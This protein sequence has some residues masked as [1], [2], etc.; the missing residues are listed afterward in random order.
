MSI[1]DKFSKTYSDVK[2]AVCIPARDQMHT[3]TSFCLYQLATVLTNLGIDNKLFVSSGTLIVNQRHELIKA[4]KE[5]SATHVMFIDSDMEFT[6][7]CVLSLLDRQLQVVAGA[8]S[9]RA[10]PFVAT[11]WYKIGDW[12]SHVTDFNDDIVQCDAIATGFMLIEMTVFDTLPQPWFKLGWYNDQYVGEDIEFCR[13]LLDHN[14][15][16]YLDM[17]VSKKLGHLGTKSYKIQGFDT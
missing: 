3:A 16:L 1:L 11:A 5:W 4:A 13:M 6:P 12:N 14:I 9:K 2:L 7:Q 15:P 10:E 17:T 8:Y